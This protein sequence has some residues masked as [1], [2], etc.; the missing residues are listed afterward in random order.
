MRPIPLILAA[1]LIWAAAILPAAGAAIPPD[2]SRHFEAA[3]SAAVH[4]AD[5]YS[6][7]SKRK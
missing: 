1:L 4:A 2:G 5:V 3:P 7:K 6:D